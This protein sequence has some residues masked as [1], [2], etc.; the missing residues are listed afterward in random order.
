MP[1]FVLVTG[2]PASARMWEG[3]LRRME[4]RG[5]T[6]RAVDLF[7]PLPE[8]PT[9]DGL[10]SGLAARVR[11]AAVL[12]VHGSAVPVGMR[13]AAAGAVRRL[14]VTNGPVA[15]LD[16]VLRAACALSRAGG[17]ML[18]PAL[19]LPFLASSLGLR[20][21]VVNPYVMD[22]DTVVAI[23]GPLVASASRRSAVARF[24]GSLPAA[25]EHPPEIGIPVL[26]AWGDADRLYPASHADS[27]R[28]WFRDP[29]EAVIA[30]GRHHHPV[31]RPWELADL[32]MDW[33]P[34]PVAGG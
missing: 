6:A 19:S 14:V 26:V 3:V 29:H 4:T 9:V 12:V 22:R 5:R 27:A 30:G 32:A 31:E 7:D 20:R 16:P 11:G 28:R 34:D 8:D 18:H 24:L 23:A 21:T 13:V 1:E 33:A 25:V 10:A 15:S 17:A 2:P